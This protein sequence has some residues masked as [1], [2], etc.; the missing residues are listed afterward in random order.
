[1]DKINGPNRV[2]RGGGESCGSD[3]R[4]GGGG[5]GLDKWGELR[6]GKLRIKEKGEFR[7]V[8]KD[9]YSSR[10][11]RPWGGKKALRKVV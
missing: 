2:F 6:S 8:P 11:L 10:G 5:G 3:K 9:A 7:V 4:G 1:M